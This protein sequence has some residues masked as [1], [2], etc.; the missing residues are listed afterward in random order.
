M[1]AMYTIYKHTNIIN[2]KC[3]IGQ[4]KRKD[5]NSRWRN[6][7]GYSQCR[8]F[9]RA[10]KKYGWNSFRHDILE[11]NILTQELANEREIYYIELY[12]SIHKG[13]NAS[14][15]GHSTEYLGKE[16]LKLDKNFNIL[17]EYHSLTDAAN[18]NNLI[19][20]SI[21]NCCLCKR[22]TTGGFMWC[23]KEDYDNYKRKVEERKERKNIKIM[24]IEIKES[25]TEK[26]QEL[27]AFKLS[28]ELREKLRK[29]AYEK[30]MSLSAMIRY[31]L[32]EHYNN[33]AKLNDT[34]RG[35]VEHE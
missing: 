19:I 12:D 13:Y 27:I 11:S 30:C 7:K 29:E 3:Y 23:F 6:G 8:K 16:V 28:E 17:D 34:S 21:S 32:V 25:A 10:I 18:L 2:N 31:I 33:N 26:K 5:L 1:N 9:Y 22:Y 20:G 4:T 35:G 24:N 14:K 15:G